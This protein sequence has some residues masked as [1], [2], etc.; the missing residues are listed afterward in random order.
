M[1]EQTK[2]GMSPIVIVGIIALLALG[3][4]AYMMMGNN[5]AATTENT[6][7]TVQEETAT[8]AQ[9]QTGSA[10]SSETATSEMVASDEVQ[11]VNVEA[12]SFYYKP[13][14]IRVKKGDTVKIVM[15]SVSM[16]HDFVIDE[17]DVRMPV[18]KNGEMGEVEFT[19]TEAGEFEYYCS[20][21]QHRANGQVGKLIVEE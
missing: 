14:E 13:N 12:G 3:G 15:K 19:V 16:M 5:N 8:A 18:V 9:E 1:E 7:I 2:K 20:V 17:L 11:I 10:E 4:I 21:G 6:E